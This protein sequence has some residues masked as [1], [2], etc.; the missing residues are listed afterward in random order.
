MDMDYLSLLENEN[1]IK[2][3]KITEVLAS[4]KLTITCLK[5]VSK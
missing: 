1:P 4:E 5:M 3:V 2:L